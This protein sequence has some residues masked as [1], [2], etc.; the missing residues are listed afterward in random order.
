MNSDGNTHE[1]EAVT[2]QQR[3]AQLE[4]F[5]AWDVRRVSCSHTH[6]R[7]PL[8]TRYIFQGACQSGRGHLDA[9]RRASCALGMYCC[10]SPVAVVTMLFCPRVQDQ[11]LLLLPRLHR[12]AARDGRG[13]VMAD[14]RAYVH[15]FLS[16]GRFRLGLSEV[17]TAFSHA[18]FNCVAVSA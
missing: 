6:P 10:C 4:W 3:R 13:D 2:S 5:W 16:H 8:M 7:W 12:R 18:A 15:I 9:I 17:T 1:R 14:G 11:G